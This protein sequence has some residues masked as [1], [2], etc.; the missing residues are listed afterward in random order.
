MLTAKQLRIC[1]ALFQHQHPPDA[2][3]EELQL[4]QSPDWCQAGCSC[5]VLQEPAIQTRGRTDKQYMYL[6]SDK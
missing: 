1:G 5:K 2:P 4:A 6:T 3:C